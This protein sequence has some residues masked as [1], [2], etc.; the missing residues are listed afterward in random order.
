MSLV[1]LRKTVTALL[2]LALLLIGFKPMSE[3]AMAAAMDAQ[4][5]CC[6]D[7][8]QPMVPDDGACGVTGG[9]AVAPSLTVLSATSVPVLFPSLVSLP[10]P[11]Q[12]N[13]ASADTSP[14]FRPPRS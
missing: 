2:V 13:L 3:T 9:C 1:M 6:A 4:Q 7:C 11:D 5:P 12:P 8:D 10:L 14:P